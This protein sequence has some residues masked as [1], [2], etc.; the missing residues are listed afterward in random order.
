[1]YSVFVHTA[2]AMCSVG[3]IINKGDGMCTFLLLFSSSLAVAVT[4]SALF[5]D[6]LALPQEAF[7][8]NASVPLPDT[9][10]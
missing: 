8:S 5:S 2:E 3:V 10:S 6:I 9:Y 7:C 4:I 1:M